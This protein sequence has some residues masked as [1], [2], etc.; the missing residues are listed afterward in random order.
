MQCTSYS[1]VRCTF[2]F[3][4]LNRLNLPS[5]GSKACSKGSGS[6]ARLMKRKPSQVATDTGWSGQSALSKF[7]MSAVEGAPMSRPSSA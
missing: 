7:S 5:S 3:G 4:M 1:I 2:R 6:S